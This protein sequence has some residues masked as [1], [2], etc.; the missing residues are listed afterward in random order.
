[1]PAPNLGAPDCR[2][3][4]TADARWHSRASWVL[5]RVFALGLSTGLGGWMRGFSLPGLFF[6]AALPFGWACSQGGDSATAPASADSAGGS[7]VASLSIV[8]S[9]L[10]DSAGQ[11]SRLTAIVKDSA[12]RPL[13]GIKVNWASSAPAVARVDGTG[14]VDAVAPGS[15]VI[16]AT[17]GGHSATAS[18]VVKPVASTIA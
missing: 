16:S 9:S 18:I 7:V 14:L 13:S 2:L 6:V 3:A 11:G 4:A 15:A 1:M 17:A 12:G 8:P 10:S 5:W